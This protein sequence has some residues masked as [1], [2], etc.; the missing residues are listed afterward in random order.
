MNVASQTQPT[1]EAKDVCTVVVIYED[2]VTRQ[3]ALSVCDYLMQE[4]WAQVEFDFHWWRTDFLEH[5]VMARAAAE[6]AV[7]ADFV[8]VCCETANELSPVVRAWFENWIEERQG[9]DGALLNLAHSVQPGRPIDR[10][11]SSVARRGMLDYFITAPQPAIGAL[12]G[13][14]E[15]AERR[16]SQMSSVLDEILNLPPRPPSWGLND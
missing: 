1:R 7:E 6:R 16:A 2:T 10:F 5:E 15:E 4:L 14:F 9:R 3:R 12:P 8:I 13:S 11:L